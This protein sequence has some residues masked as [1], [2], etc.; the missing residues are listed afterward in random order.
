MHC[1]LLQHGIAVDYS[2]VVKPCCVWHTNTKWQKK[3]HITTIDLANWHDND[4]LKAFRQIMSQNIWP[5]ECQSCAQE[6]IKGRFDSL[7]GN[8]NRAYQDFNADEITL[9]IRPGS[10]CNFACQTCCPEASSRV[11]DFYRKAKLANVARVVKPSAKLF[12]F[13]LPIKQRIKQVILLGGEPFYDPNCLKFLD[14]AAQNFS[15]HITMFTNGSMLDWQWLSKYSGSVTLVFSIDAVGKPAEYVRFG[16]I[17]KDIEKNFRQARAL[18]NVN[19][20]VNVTTSIYNYFYL[21]DLINWLILDWPEVVSF[22]KTE[23]VSATGIDQRILNESLVP[24]S[25]RPIL[26]DSLNNSLS[27]LKQA[28]IEIGQSQNA[29]GA[30]QAIINQLNVTAFDDKNFAKWKTFVSKMDAVKKINIAD[31]C[32]ELALLLGHHQP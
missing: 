30:V 28:N 27:A 4:D 26:I 17:W 16:T 9:E 19:I 10:V 12:D 13:L 18:D 29:Q 31:F 24:L 2:G 15:S 23:S 1:K 11:A 25:L 20:R 5:S 22:N 21:Y 6:E 32:P 8:A 7:R 3:N 14:W